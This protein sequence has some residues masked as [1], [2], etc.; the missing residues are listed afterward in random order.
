MSWQEVLGRRSLLPYPPMQ[1]DTMCLCQFW[2]G[3]TIVISHSAIQ[4]VLEVLLPNFLLIHLPRWWKSPGYLHR[5]TQGRSQTEIKQRCQ[6]E[7]SGT[8]TMIQFTLIVSS[9]PLKHSDKKIPGFS[10]SK[11][12]AGTYVVNTSLMNNILNHPLHLSLFLITGAGRA[13]AAQW[14]LKC[15]QFSTTTNMG[16]ENLN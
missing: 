11:E 6:K 10:F 4:T 3:G 8:A 9:T 7:Q 5:P 16:K 1:V 2:I 14:C 15:S 12:Y 13:S